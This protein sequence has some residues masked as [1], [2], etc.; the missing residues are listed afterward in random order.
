M[1]LLPFALALTRASRAQDFDPHGH[2]RRPATPAT[3]PSAPASSSHPGAA[4]PGGPSQAALIERYARVVLSQPGAS[5][6][7]QRLAQLYRERDGGIAKLIVDFEARAAAGGPE[8]YAATIS[9][10]GLYKLDG[11]GQDAVVA[12]EKAVALAPGDPTAPAALAHLYQDRG[13]LGPARAE[14][15]RALPLLVS[16]ADREQTLR[17]I[18]MIALD[19]KDWAAA[20][21][22]HRKLVALEPTSLFVKAELGHQ[23]YDRGE[24]ERAEEEL[25]LVVADAA[26]DNR[27]LAPALRELGRAQARAQKNEEALATLKRALDVAGPQSALRAQ[28]YETIAEI[29]RADQRLPVLVK[30]L[31]GEHPTDF[32]RLSLLGGLYEE[33]GDSAKA[34]EVYRRAL[35]TSPQQLDVRLRMIRL[36]QANGDLDQAILEYDGLIRAAPNNPQFVFE[37]CDALLQRGDHARALRLV[38]D[39][40]ARAAGDEEVLTRV[41]DFYARIGESD[42]SLRVLQRLAQSSSGDAGHLVDLGDRYFQDGDVAL[43]VQTWKRILVAVQP[44]AKALCALG[45]VFVEHDMTADAL[46]AYKGAVEL[47]PSNL[48][49]K[50]ALAAAYERNRSYREARALYEEIASKAKE[51]GDV[52]LARECRTRIVT[53]WGSSARSR[54]SCP[55]CGGTSPPPRRISTPGGCWP[56]RSSICGGCRTRRRRCAA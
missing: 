18:M 34:I 26:G 37:E 39:L 36:L 35:A 52:A 7:L 54:R 10:A 2:H 3:R 9:L 12:F 48:A 23:L 24:Y 44:R 31:E 53:L 13:D 8:Q 4:D 46:T 21:D 19:Q 56:K 50:K 1:A 42:R 30:Q 28:I 5:F 14:Y 6:P 45:D 25:K 15:E 40:E 16:R 33:T 55:D 17:T 41:A 38:T 29:Y 27:A 43:A 32:A 47:E 11:R 51:K 20:K 22:F 49:F